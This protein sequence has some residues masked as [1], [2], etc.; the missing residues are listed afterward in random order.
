MTEQIV[1][2][3]GC[4]SGIGLETAIYLAERGFKVYA[5]I[6]DLEKRSTLEAEANRRKVP[7]ECLQLDVTDLRS[8]T[9]A[10]ETVVKR[11]GT[12]Y[13]LV[14]NAGI[15]IRGFFEDLSEDE[16]RRVFNVN[17]F[18]TMAATRAVL[19]YMR[20]QGRGRII[21]MSSAGG[22]L[23][24]LG[25]SAYCTS[26]FALEGFAQTLT[27][28]VKPFGLS[29]SLVEPGFVKTELF[30]KNRYIASRALDQKGP[31]REWFLRLEQFTDQLV[32]APT[33]S[34]IDVAAAVFKALTAKHP[35]LTYI[36]GRRTK[37]LIALR[38]YLPG[39][40]FDRVWMM[41][42]ARRIQGTS[43]HGA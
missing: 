32:D 3:T 11:S 16:M 25:S 26:K 21:I 22:K 18:G 15:N 6:R 1:L 20:S 38:R 41:E 35:R 28:E 29:V 17:V 30:G 43:R 27:Q 33:A 10:I 13:G 19:P 39:E 40:L 9:N 8:V 34:T 5:T 12:I 37:V 36:V 42:A 23:P 31:Y 2:V 7:L 14:N 4:S 24:A